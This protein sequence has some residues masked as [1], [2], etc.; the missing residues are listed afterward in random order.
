MGHIEPF[1]L[2]IAVKDKTQTTDMLWTL[3]CILNPG[4]HTACPSIIR[5]AHR[6][7]NTVAERLWVAFRGGQFGIGGQ[8]RDRACIPG[9]VAVIFH[10][11]LLQ[12]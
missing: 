12:F 4:I 5:I 9:E 3:K 6:A 2:Q 1:A 8:F 10:E 11:S 7:I